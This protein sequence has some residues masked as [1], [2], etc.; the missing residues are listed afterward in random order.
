[1]TAERNKAVVT[2]FNKE[3]VEQGNMASFR[4]LL[5]ADV[6]NHA[7]PPGTP[8]GPD[9]M[10]DFLQNVLRVGFPDL[11]VEILE[12]VAERDLVTTRKRIRGTHAGT[13]MG[14]QATGKTVEISVIDMVRVRD[15]K[16]VEHWGLS[17][18]P[19]VLAGLSRDGR[20]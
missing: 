20:A 18:L 12:Q 17:N 4:E 8:A 6:V 5:A 19:E 15:G 10:I 16:Y 7:A 11:K 9:S 2:R 14:V 3:C 1:M 13:F